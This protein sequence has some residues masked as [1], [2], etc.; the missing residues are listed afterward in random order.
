LEEKAFGSDGS[1]KQPKALSINKMGHA[2]H[3]LDPVF[4]AFSR[5]DKVGCCTL[6]PVLKAPGSSA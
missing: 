3:D 4:R 1:L 5:S 6:K 2:M